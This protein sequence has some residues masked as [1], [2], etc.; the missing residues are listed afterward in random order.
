M[1]NAGVMMSDRVYHFEDVTVDSARFQVLRAGAPLALEP[2]ALDVLLFL[3]ERLD[4]SAELP[5][6]LWDPERGSLGGATRRVAVCVV[7]RRRIA[8]GGVRRCGWCRRGVRRGGAARW[9]VLWRGRRGG[10]GWV[11]GGGVRWRR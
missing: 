9:W 3:I 10:R 1:M 4:R 7:P 8:V 5:R 6:R 2:K 11:G